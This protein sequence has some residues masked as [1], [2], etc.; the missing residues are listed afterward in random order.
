MHVNSDAGITAPKVDGYTFVCWFACVSE[1]WVGTCYIEKP[2]SA[3][4]RTWYVNQRYNSGGGTVGCYALY[5][6]Q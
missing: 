5:V 1:G 2:T 4:T 6:H 3:V